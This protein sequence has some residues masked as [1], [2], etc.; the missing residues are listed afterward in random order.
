MKGLI[1]RDDHKRLRKGFMALGID[2]QKARTFAGMIASKNGKAKADVLIGLGR[3]G[4]ALTD[5]LIGDDLMK[6]VI[7]AGNGTTITLS[8]F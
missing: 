2:S 8:I 7:V 3:M 1:D 6:D 5:V 4:F